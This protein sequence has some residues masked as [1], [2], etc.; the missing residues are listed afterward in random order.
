AVAAAGLAWAALSRARTSAA[1]VAVGIVGAGY[2]GLILVAGSTLIG[3][4]GNELSM[5]AFRY[6]HHPESP[7]NQMAMAQ[8]LFEIGRYRE[9]AAVLDEAA[10][11][12]PDDIAFA[13]ARLE[14]ACAAPALKPASL[15]DAQRRLAEGSH[16]A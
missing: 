12:F 10:A 11:R 5:A 1:R 3:L 4:W 13:V 9:A 15:D 16:N 6:Q 7:R 14:L 2:L 8:K